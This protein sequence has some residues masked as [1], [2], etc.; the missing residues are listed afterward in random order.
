VSGFRRIGDV[1]EKRAIEF[2]LAIGYSIVT[3]NYKRGASEIDIVAKDGDELVFVEVRSRRKGAWETAEES[4]T[5]AKQKRLWKTAEQYLAEMGQSDH[6]C[7]FD[8][9][10][11]NGKELN[12]YKDA[13][14]P[15][16]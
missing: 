10:A 1:G 7:R 8:V 6:I 15:L 5:P 9:V 3:R 2:L 11:I 16:L 14:R 12:H 13:F 4:I